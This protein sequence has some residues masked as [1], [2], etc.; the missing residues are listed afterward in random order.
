[1]SSTYT[2]S[3]ISGGGTINASGLYTAPPIATVATVQ[4][5][6]SGKTD[7]ATVNVTRVPETYT[8]DGGST[9]DSNWSTPENWVG[10]IAPIAGDSLVFPAG[11]ARLD[12]VNDYP[13]GTVFGSITVSGSGYKITNGGNIIP[14]SIQVQP[15][16]QLEADKIVTGTLTIGAGAKVTITPI[17]GGPLA[18]NSTLIAAYNKCCAR[19]NVNISTSQP[20]VAS[21]NTTPPTS[22][23]TATSPVEPLA[24]S[25]AFV[26]PISD[27]STVVPVQASTSSLSNTAFNT[28]DAITALPARTINSTTP[29]RLF[30]SAFNHITSQLPAASH[31][32]IALNSILESRLE[33]PQTARQI[34]NIPKTSAL[35]SSQDGFPLHA[36]KSE[37]NTHLH[38]VTNRQAHFTALQAIV[39]KADQDI[40]FDT[41]NNIR[42]P[43]H[44]QRLEKAID[45]VLAGDGGSVK[46]ML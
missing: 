13:A 40:A 28:I 19:Q 15:D 4:A 11:A 34:N 5:V 45:E 44:I 18:A 20:T 30:N 24:A 12:N 7:T 43:K 39:E 33:N 21:T 27:F 25:T 41:T 29:A 46:A 2:W 9:V 32:L 31:N 10:D 36:G 35:T 8:W 16:M 26:T 6:S 3:V 14:A 23:A 42:G 38:T 17:A 37:K 1:M 22:A